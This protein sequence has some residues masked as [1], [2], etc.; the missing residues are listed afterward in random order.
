MVFQ[1][2]LALTEKEWELKL[3]RWYY[4]CEN[5]MDPNEELI[6]YTEA[7]TSWTQRQLY[8]FFKIML[9]KMSPEER[10]NTISVNKKSRSFE[11]IEQQT[12]I[13]I[14]KHVTNSCIL[15]DN[16]CHTVT[17]VDKAV[18][19]DCN[20]NDET[21][22]DFE[23]ASGNDESTIGDIDDDDNEYDNE[24]SD[25][26]QGDSDDSSNEEEDPCLNYIDLQKLPKQWKQ[27]LTRAVDVCAKKI[28]NLS[29]ELLQKVHT[30]QDI[31]RIEMVKNISQGQLAIFHKVKEI[32]YCE[33]Q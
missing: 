26:S 1:D 18:V 25:G 33:L 5:S 3:S 12:G 32:L 8:S 4:E 22:D 9:E 19:D 10:R 30:T 27:I 15:R 24:R 13:V 6:F 31:Q 7:G 28:A 14:D 2:I 16:E 29:K 17:E 21:S 20:K 23:D 11:D